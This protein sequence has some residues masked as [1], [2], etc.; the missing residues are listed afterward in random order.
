MVS[1]C[2]TA[3][4]SAAERTRDFDSSERCQNPNPAP[5]VIA[6]SN[7]AGTGLLLAITFGAGFGFWHLSELSK[8][9]V[10]SAALDGAVEQAETM[11]EANRY[12]SR[13]GAPLHRAELG[14]A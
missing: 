5:K 13:V 11:T 7:P 3:P 8:S 14:R 4:S 9:L 2:S 12:Y 6:R 10:R 1:A